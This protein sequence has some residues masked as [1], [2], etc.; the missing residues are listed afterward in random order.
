MWKDNLLQFELSHQAPCSLLCG[1]GGKSACNAS[2]V[3]RIR[4]NLLF[5]LFS[6]QLSA[7]SS[8]LKKNKLLKTCCLLGNNTSK[9]VQNKNFLWKASKDF[10]QNTGM[11]GLNFVTSTL[12]MLIN[13]KIKGM[14]SHTLTPT[15]TRV[16]K[17]KTRRLIPITYQYQQNSKIQTANQFQKEEWS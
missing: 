13:A 17:L 4:T 14:S 10:L 6:L 8:H 3:Y 15:Y 12:W 5:H 11:Y 16:Q 9:R 1:V 2:H 7:I